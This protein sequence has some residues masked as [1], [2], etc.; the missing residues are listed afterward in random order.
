MQQLSMSRLSKM[1][2]EI[3]EVM[4]EDYN[5]TYF[6]I[7]LYAYEHDKDEWI[8][9]FEYDDDIRYKISKLVKSCRPADFHFENRRRP[10]K[11]KYKEIIKVAERAYRKRYLDRLH[12]KY[13]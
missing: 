1:Y 8:R 6:D 4:K 7:I 2:S 13:A 3:I 11:Q 5:Q 12:Q 10:T 9:A